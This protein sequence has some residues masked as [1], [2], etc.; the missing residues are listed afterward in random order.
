MKSSGGSCQPRKASAIVRGAV[1]KAGTQAGDLERTLADVRQG[2]AKASATF[3][4]AAALLLLLSSSS[5]RAGVVPVEEQWLATMGHHDIRT[6]HIFIW[7]QVCSQGCVEAMAATPGDGASAACKWSTWAVRLGI[8]PAFLPARSYMLKPAWALGFGR[9]SDMCQFIHKCSCS[10][11]SPWGTMGGVLHCSRTWHCG[12][13]RHRP[14]VP[15]HMRTRAR[16]KE[17]AYDVWP[18][19]LRPNRIKTLE[20]SL[21]IVSGCHGER[22]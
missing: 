17:V 6:C 2:T 11:A 21:M 4:K 7:P 10:D 1:V 20:S 12:K 13:D 5:L 22:R 8:D 15:F 9:A 14:L 18:L 16:T 3:R 19:R